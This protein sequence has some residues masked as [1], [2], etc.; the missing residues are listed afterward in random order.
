MGHPKP[1]PRATIEI[2]NQ[3]RIPAI[4]K[5]QKTE[6]EDDKME[7]NKGQTKL[8][9][10]KRINQNRDREERRKRD[11]RACKQQATKLE[12]KNFINNIFFIDTF[13]NSIMHNTSIAKLTTPITNQISETKWLYYFPLQRNTSKTFGRG[14]PKTKSPS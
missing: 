7:H 9:R 8:R 3:C 11:F 2:G 13:H 10:K 12:I 1:K 4:W 5:R 6:A 14:C